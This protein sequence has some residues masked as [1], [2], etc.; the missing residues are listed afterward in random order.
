M[1]ILRKCL[2]TIAI[3]FAISSNGFSQEKTT[4]PSLTTP[5]GGDTLG[6]LSEVISTTTGVAISPLATM[7]VLGAWKYF[8]ADEQTRS[9]LEWFCNPAIWG[10]ALLVGGLLL[11]KSTGKVVIPA[12]L[13]APVDLIDHFVRHTAK[14]IAGICTVI[15]A[16]MKAITAFGMLNQSQDG[17]MHASI[18]PLELIPAWGVATAITSFIFGVVWMSFN[19]VDTLVMLC[20]VGPVELISKLLKGA[21]LVLILLLTAI[22]PILAL[23]LCAV[24]IFIATKV[25]AWAYRLTIFGYVIM[26]DL[27][28]P[29]SARKKVDVNTP[30]A[31]VKCK[32]K[33]IAARTYGKI[34]KEDGNLVFRYRPVFFAPT[35]TVILPNTDR[36]IVWGILMSEINDTVKTNLFCK[37]SFSPRYK[38]HEEAIGAALGIADIRDCGL[39]RGW[40]GF[41]LWFADTFFGKPSK[42]QPDL[43]QLSV[44]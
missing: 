10:L 14:P 29:S 20:P 37:V 32:E 19:A 42:Q 9:S 27:L 22:S 13:V 17:V 3:I 41:K 39:I 8:N 1:K 30:H 2:F 33:K 36:H 31:F 43:P 40:K 16:S 28:F 44:S 4:N 25:A 24:I 6:A 26:Y 7:G 35:R 34:S 15:P 11:L 18:I 21:I 5:T 12:A 38:K 23:L